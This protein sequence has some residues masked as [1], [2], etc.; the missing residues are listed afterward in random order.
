[1][2]SFDVFSAEQVEQLTKDITT[3]FGP[4]VLQFWNETTNFLIVY[5]RNPKTTEKCTGHK[6]HVFIYFTTCVLNS[7]ILSNKYF[8]QEVQKKSMFVTIL[9]PL[10]WSH[11]NQTWNAMTKFSTPS[12]Y[13]VSQKSVW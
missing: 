3:K 11:F 8:Y 2:P 12:Q 7:F 5:F 1:M 4:R 6:M 9:C 13:Q 10:F